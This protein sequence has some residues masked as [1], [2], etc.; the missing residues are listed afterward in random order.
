[1][2]ALG[3]TPT[4]PLATADLTT[5]CG[6]LDCLLTAVAFRI[7]RELLFAAIALST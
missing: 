6:Q 4:R 3:N 5:S 7:G 1:M 2:G